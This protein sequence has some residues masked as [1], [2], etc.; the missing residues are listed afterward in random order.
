MSYDSGSNYKYPKQEALDNIKKELLQSEEIKKDFIFLERMQEFDLT[1]NDVKWVKHLI[2]L[3]EGRGIKFLLNYIQARTG[4]AIAHYENK[5]INGLP[6]GKF[7][8]RS[9]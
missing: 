6:L 1:E 8:E 3:P 2:N 4:S 9:I 7:N 5:F